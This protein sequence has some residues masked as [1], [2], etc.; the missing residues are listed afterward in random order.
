MIVGNAMM[1][2]RIRRLLL[3]SVAIGVTI[4]AVAQDEDSVVDEADDSTSRCISLRTVRSTD[5][6]DDRN[7][8]FHM[9]GSIVY[10]NI[11]P[12]KCNGLARE[13]RFSYRT[14]IG[15][16]CSNDI[17]NVLYNNGSGLREGNACQ[18][19]IFY[20][21]TREDAKAFKDAPEPEPQANPLPM[22]APQEVGAD[23]EEPEEPKE[24]EPPS[25]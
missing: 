12:R 24:P 21:M 13:D 8:L 1:Y 17:I 6:V 16:L 19:G 20:E 22:P 3:I 23:E 9:R 10:H 25:H 4:P 7:I 15:R 2:K 18:L 11:L 14:T 5:V